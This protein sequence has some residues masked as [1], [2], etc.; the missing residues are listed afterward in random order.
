MARD[1]AQLRR[2][3]SRPRPILL[4]RLGVSGPAPPPPRALHR[5]WP[6]LLA[7]ELNEACRSGMMEGRPCDT[8]ERINDGQTGL[9]QVGDFRCDEQG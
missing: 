9:R 8:A 2:Q 1:K 4:T 5:W 3:A 6:G 7:V